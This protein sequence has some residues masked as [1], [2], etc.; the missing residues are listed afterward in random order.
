MFLEADVNL[1]PSLT[2]E[3]RA[4]DLSPDNLRQLVGLVEHDSA[5]DPFPVT[6][7]DAVV[8]VAGNATQSSAYF[9]TVLDMDA[10]AHRTADRPCD[11]VDRR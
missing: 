3:E 7:W 1:D 6:G 5:H 4:A 2:A 11:I 8:W 10:R 9:Q